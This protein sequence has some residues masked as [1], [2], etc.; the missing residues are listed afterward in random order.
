[1]GNQAADKVL[2]KIEGTWRLSDPAT[3]EGLNKMVKAINDLIE[4]NVN[5]KAKADF[6]KVEVIYGNLGGSRASLRVYAAG[7]PVAE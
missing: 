6:T 1:M 2:K 3:C 4:D 7:Q 5:G